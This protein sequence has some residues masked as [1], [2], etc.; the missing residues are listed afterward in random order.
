MPFHS[1]AH[2]G[3]LVLMT[4]SSGT[5]SLDTSLPPK[6]GVKGILLSNGMIDIKCKDDRLQECR[7]RIYLDSALTYSE[8][9]LVVLQTHGIVVVEIEVGL[10]RLLAGGVGVAREEHR[11]VALTADHPD[12]VRGAL[13]V[14]A[15][16][17]AAGRG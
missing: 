2:P 17:E 13:Q 14:G 9:N 5:P 10:L 1:I 11:V 7:R 6:S 4:L 12:W 3:H 16:L 8:L 15:D